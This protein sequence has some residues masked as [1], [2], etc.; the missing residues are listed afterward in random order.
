MDIM[1]HAKF[2][3]NRLMLTLIFAIRASEPPRAWR[4]TKKAGP[5]RVKELWE[6][7][8]H[9]ILDTFCIAQ[10][11]YNF[12]ILGMFAV[13]KCRGHTDFVLSKTY[14]EYF[15]LILIQFG[16]L[17]LVYLE[18]QFPGKQKNLRCRFSRSSLNEVL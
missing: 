2:Y 14:D 12:T 13:A 3:F 8:H 15:H 5:D 18:I 7:L 17:K 4:T 1:T 11:W 9:R 10:I 16:T 6:N